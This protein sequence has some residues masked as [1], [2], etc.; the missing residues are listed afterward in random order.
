M[1]NNVYPL[2]LP[3]AMPPTQASRIAQGPM[4]TAVAH[5]G[6]GDLPPFCDLGKLSTFRC[7]LATHVSTLAIDIGN[8]GLYI[9]MGASLMHGKHCKH[10]KHSKHSK[11]ASK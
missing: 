8:G 5:R 2:P 10:S 4:A 9:H 7:C 1:N 3:K 6:S 11:Q